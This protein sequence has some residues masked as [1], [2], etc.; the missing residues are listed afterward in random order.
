MSAGEHDLEELIK[1][2]KAGPQWKDTLV[3]ITTDEHGGFWDHVPPPKRDEFGRGTRIP[4][5]A[6]GPMVK[7]GY[8]DHTQYDFGSILRT[9]EE[10]PAKSAF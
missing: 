1:L 5:I 8:I 2:L 9:I 6:V 4:L 7:R 3:L 10:Y